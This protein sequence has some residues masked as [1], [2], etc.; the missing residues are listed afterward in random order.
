MRSLLLLR[1]AQTESTRPGSGDHARRLT[2][3]GEQQAAAV[4][5]HLRNTQTEL[6]LVLCS[7]ASRARQ[8]AALLRTAAPV[9]V[10]DDLYEAG[11]D[12]IIA[13]VRDLAHDVGHVLVVAH[14][15]GL[16]SVVHQLAD[17]DASDPQAL[18]TVRSRYPAGTLAVMAVTQAWPELDRAALVSVRVP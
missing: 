7:S 8:T 2:P 6:D 9:V 13:L 12:E 10:S 3:V 1:H 4:G 17:Q 18:A 15:P 5:D 16:P 11:G 14:A